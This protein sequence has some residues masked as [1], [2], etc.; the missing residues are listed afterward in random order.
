MRGV[1]SAFNHFTTV[2]LQSNPFVAIG[3]AWFTKMF[4]SSQGEPEHSPVSDKSQDSAIAPDEADEVLGEDHKSLLLQLI[5]A[6]GLSMGMDLS[7]VVLPTFILEPRSLL[8][9]LGDIC[10]HPEI[11]A[12]IPKAATPQE[13]IVAVCRWYMS[14]FHK[15]PRGV[16]KPFNPVL[17]ESYHGLFT[18]ADGASKV[19]WRS[20]QVSHHPPVSAFFATTSA[21]DVVLQGTFAPKSRFLGNSAASIGE[22]GFELYLPGIEEVYAITWPTVYVRGLVFGTLLMELGGPINIRCPKS[23]FH[24]DLEFIVKGYFSG[25]RN[26]VSGSIFRQADLNSPKNAGR[27]ILFTV[28]G[29]WTKSVSL[30]EAKTG[31]STILFDVAGNKLGTCATD[32]SDSSSPFESTTTWASVT[33]AIVA[34]DQ[35]AATDFKTAIEE[36]QRALRT[37]RKEQG[38]EWRPRLFDSDGVNGDCEYIG[39]DAVKI[40]S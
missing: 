8:E 31:A 9:K 17:G 13:R 6:N 20:E 7:R 30:K 29:D 34:G 19:V 22:G 37:Q 33:K 5:K 4:K 1:F 12:A 11:L 16:K 27:E 28:E 36:Q 15:R 14:A 38:I 32:L 3:M 25:T 2:L 23:G 26:A 18:S 21:K 40:P 24:C 10:I 35:K 39:P